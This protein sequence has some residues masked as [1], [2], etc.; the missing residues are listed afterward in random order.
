MPII[1]AEGVSCSL[2]GRKVLENFSLEVEEGEIVGLLGPSGCGKSTFMNLCIGFLQ[3]GGG[4][5]SVLGRL[6]AKGR[7][8]VGFAT[9]YDSFYEELTVWENI[10]YFGKLSDLSGEQVR[11]SASALLPAMDLAGFEKR[12]AGQLS[13]GQKRR[14]NLLLSLLSKPKLLL[15]DE[16]TVGLDPVTRKSIWELLFQLK[17]SGVTILLT[18]H[19]MFEAEALCD[20]IA[21]MDRGGVAAAGSVEE[22]RAR[23]VPDELVYLVTR[24]GNPRVL[25]ELEQHLL[26]QNV[27]ESM[28]SDAKGNIITTHTPAKAIAGI[29]AFLRKT[30]ESIVFMDVE[31]PSF[32]RVFFLATR[33]SGEQ[34][35]EKEK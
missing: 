12:L 20:R 1:S 25:K 29:S 8:D 14:L 4:A 26:R 13:G 16:P 21:I 23:F 22:L 31:K 9:Q 34:L 33:Q 18:T 2:G 6:P 7:L 17:S 24:P 19:Y 3:A 35:A 11:E 28:V 10:D 27:A 32:E 30:G 15:V 5:L